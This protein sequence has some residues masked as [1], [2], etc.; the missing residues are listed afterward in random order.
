MNLTKDSFLTKNESNKGKKVGPC[1]V[2]PGKGNWFSA[3]EIHLV[4]VGKEKGWEQT[5]GV[6][7]GF[8]PVGIQGSRKGFQ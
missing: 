2:G 3:A 7:S 8:S 5:G 4:R 6:Y 1:K